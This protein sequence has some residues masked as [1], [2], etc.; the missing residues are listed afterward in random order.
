MRPLL[1]IVVC[2]LLTA[3]AAVPG[4]PITAASAAAPPAP[5]AAAPPEAS[6]AEYICTDLDGAPSVEDHRADRQCSQG[7]HDRG[8]LGAP[9]ATSA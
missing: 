1:T 5:S 3:C 8:E 9:L 7:G 2:S 4:P 6:P